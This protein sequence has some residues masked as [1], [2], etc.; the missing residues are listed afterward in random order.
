MK[1]CLLG[2]LVLLGTCSLAQAEY[3]LIIANLNP[4]TQGSE[5]NNLGGPGMGGGVIGG[6]GGPRGGGPGGLAG[7]GS[8][9][10]GAGFGGNRGGQGPMGGVIGGSAMGGPRG[11]GPAIAPPTTDADE[12]EDLVV[13]I[14]EVTNF[15]P[16]NAKNWKNLDAP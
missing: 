13:T 2:L 5:G 1:R 12:V 4:K 16:L 14:L 6:T 3:I 7:S 11:G 15:T 10:A 9:L 8:G